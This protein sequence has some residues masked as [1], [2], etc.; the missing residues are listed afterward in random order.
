MVEFRHRKD[1]GV[2]QPRLRNKIVHSLIKKLEQM[3]LYITF[4]E[5][6]SKR[7]KELLRTGTVN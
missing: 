3:L 7:G 6:V 5:V 1:I 4:S 2:D